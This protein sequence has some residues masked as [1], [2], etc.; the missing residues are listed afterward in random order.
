MIKRITTAADLE[1]LREHARSARKLKPIQVAVCS[2]TGCLAAKS[3][4][5]A[6]LLEEEVDRQGLTSRVEVRRT[7]CFGFCE[8]GPV[9]VIQPLDV[10]YLKVGVNDVEE[11]VRR[12][13]AEGE[14]VE[15]LLFHT[16]EGRAVRALNDIPFYVGQSRVLLHANTQI[17]PTSLEEY[18]SIGGYGALS[19]ALFEMAPREVVDLIKASGLRGRGGG[20]FPT[21]VKWESSRNAPG[22]EKYVIVNADEGDPGAY[23][24][25][26]LLEGNPHA[27]LEGLIIGGYAVGARQGYIYVRQEYPL[28]VEN[29][30][31]AIDQAYEY[32]LLGSDILGSGLRLD[33]KIHRGAGAFVSGESTALMRAIEG[34]VGEPRPK[35]IHTSHHGLWN[36]PTVLNNVE[37]WANVPVILNLGLKRYRAL[38]TD[39][40][41]GTKIFSLVGKV[42]NSGLVEVPM[43]MT[44]RQLVEDIGGGVPGG[45][46]IKAVQTGGPSGGFIPA[47]RLDLPVDFDALDEAGSMMGSG[48]LIVM[49]E[50]TCI[51]DA[52]RYYVN[53]L[54]KES[55]GQC[56]PCREGLRQLSKILDGMVEGRG[57]MQDIETMEEICELLETA[58]LCALGRTAPNPVRSALRYFRDE[59][60]AHARDRRC[61]SLVCESMTRYVIDASSCPGCLLCMKVC[62]TDAIEGERKHPHRIDQ[63]KCIQCGNC[64]AACP[65]RI[66]A[67]HKVPKSPSMDAPRPRA[68]V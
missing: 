22:D 34:F 61:P 54:A 24:D 65:P 11:L 38:G 3:K 30:Q 35:Y 46:A 44:L 17:T 2:G 37:T 62:P 20:G 58:S 33:V 7:G 45:K 68:Q 49:D 19:R 51:V 55:C 53:F 31:R 43:G 27:I 28:A 57:T 41:K 29:A 48:G 47:S 1:T 13:L 32:G 39:G 16:P 21:G 5:M 6:D 56:V 40:S 52:T 10:C 15:R 64:L 50:D 25:R 23:M 8:Q 9:M 14:V 67:V 4:T 63:D 66:S 42:R 60:E 59:F 26:S 36:S 12:T 18:L